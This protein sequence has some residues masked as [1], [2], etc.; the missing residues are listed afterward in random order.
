M[1]EAVDQ[2]T[3][4]RSLPLTFFMRHLAHELGNPVASIRMSAE[5]LIGDFPQEMHQEL[6]QIIMSESLRL[7]S[8]IESA[9]YFS[10][11][12][13]PAQHEIEFSA[14][15]DSAVKQGEITIPVRVHSE[16]DSDVII[17]DASQ[18]ARLFREI[19]RNAMQAGGETI[20]VTLRNEGDLLL[21]TIVDD[22][23]GIV[24][25]KFPVV[26]DPFYTSRDG[27]LGLG[28]NIVR[29]IVELHRGTVEISRA[30]PS[31]TAVTIRLPQSSE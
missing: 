2:Q 6:F 7:E 16:I 18:F 17:G 24:D 8:L 4:D 14:L 5:M 26:F 23:S 15:I 30:E 13:A 21:I 1:N 22:G 29:R 12:G 9:V 10:S 20:N 11:L 19:F 31:G 25:E 28:L 27:Q 3:R